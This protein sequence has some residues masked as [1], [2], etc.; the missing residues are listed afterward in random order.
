MKFQRR[1]IVFAF[2]F[3]SGH[4]VG[5]RPTDATIVLHG[6][7]WLWVR[8]GIA[9]RIREDM[10]RAGLGGE[11]LL[12]SFVFGCILVAFCLNLASQV[13]YER[14]GAILFRINPF[15]RRFMAEVLP[16]GLEGRDELLMEC[17]LANLTFFRQDHEWRDF[18]DSM[19]NYS[20]F[21]LDARPPHLVARH[22]LAYR[23]EA[24]MECVRTHYN[25]LPEV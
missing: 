7:R 5:V 6:A 21:T 8:L 12:F 13:L 14:F 20:R 24:W 4:R 1:G 17:I 11:N 15:W 19:L 22:A 18:Y 25:G 9:D 3:C 23:S 10:F 2:F 16:R